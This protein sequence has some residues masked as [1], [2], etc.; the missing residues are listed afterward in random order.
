MREQSV[1]NATVAVGVDGFQ[2]SPEMINVAGDAKN[3]P[4]AKAEL[5]RRQLQQR[6]HAWVLERPHV[7]VEPLQHP[8]LLPHQNRHVIPDNL[9]LLLLRSP[10]PPHQLNSLPCLSTYVYKAS[11]NYRQTRHGVVLSWPTNQIPED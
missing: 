3:S 11:I 10:P 1:Y 6:H 4:V 9:H 5:L 2:Q 7:H 8:I